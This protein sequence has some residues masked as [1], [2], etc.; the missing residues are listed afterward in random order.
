MK[1]QTIDTAPK[2]GTHILLYVEDQGIVEGWWYPADWHGDG[3]WWDYITLSAHGCGCCQ[4]YDDNPT[5]WMPMP[6]MPF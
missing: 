6:D 1:W 3:G 4:S 5:F 2:D